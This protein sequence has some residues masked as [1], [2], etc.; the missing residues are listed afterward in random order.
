MKFFTNNF[1]KEHK[2]SFIIFDFVLLTLL[3][4]KLLHFYNMTVDKFILP[5]A[6]ATVFILSV[7]FTLILFLSPK[8]AT[9]TLS[10]FY[11][12]LSVI[13]SVDLVYYRYMGSV[14]SFGLLKMA[15]QLGG[16]KG[17]LQELIGPMQLLPL[18]DLPVVF[19]LVI[20][21]QLFKKVRTFLIS[22]KTVI[23]SA[24]SAV[25]VCLLM[26]S[27]SLLFGGFKFQY[28]PNEI[29]SYHANDVIELLLP[30]KLNS[31]IDKD[32]YTG[33]SSGD[34]YG[35]ANGR[36]VFVIQVE[37]FQEFVIN[38]KYKGQEITP[39]LN[40]LTQND[41]FYFENYFFMT[42]SG[43]T[44]DAEFAVNN[45]L[46]PVEYV[47]AY[48]YYLEKDF[49]GL[50]WLLR[51]KGYTEST[52][53]HGYYEYYWSRNKAYPRQGFTDFISI[54]DVEF[55]PNEGCN[56]AVEGNKANTDR[57]LYEDVIETVKTYEE[58]FYSFIVTLS[59]HMPFTVAPSD[60]YI[61][62]DNPSP[63]LFTSYLQSAAYVDKTIEE[64]MLNLK[65]EG[66]YDNS[67]FIIYGDHYAL[68]EDDS[69]LVSQIED[70]TGEPYTIVQ[71]FKVP[72]LIHIPG[73]GEA[74]TYD[75]VGSHLDVMP[76][77]LH[78]LGIKNDKAV[79]FGHNLLDPNHD[80]F[81]YELVHLK[82]G[83]FITK[84]VFFV[85]SEGNI[86]S[87]A[88][89]LEGN[90]IEI[91]DEHIKTTQKALNTINDCHALLYN[92]EILLN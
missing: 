59:S 65:A 79:M 24:V 46:Y 54:E 14:P 31:N 30:S 3:F 51:D 89:D 26:V 58:P 2:L 78:L 22:F 32:K 84:D 20:N 72:M 15:W 57:R 40:T 11:I 68:K 45:S 36:N 60:R 48:E 10:V 91:T 83:S 38:E 25:L 88:Y 77:L 74:K 70:M 75:T 13:L 73:L 81:V 86:N 27:G 69:K 28:L 7:I 41:S 21:T 8:A 6:A 29:L 18:W 71:R 47:S 33:S 76:T 16:V 55:H 4:F 17:S 66:L 50:P 39:F 62:A 53:F 23:L 67:I 42:G 34:F 90:P 19:L 63:D 35:V 80:G 85:Y 87:Q 64:F 56:F 37:A 12:L 82:M 5:L 1:S 43:N 92:N 61:D 52:A 44:S 9:I 49:R